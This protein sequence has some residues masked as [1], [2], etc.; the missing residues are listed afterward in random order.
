MFNLFFFF[1]LTLP[2]PIPEF[3]FF[4]VE[5]G[6]LLFVIAEF[7]VGAAALYIAILAYQHS[8]RKRGRPKKTKAEKLMVRLSKQLK[9]SIAL[10]KEDD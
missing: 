2:H 6:I 7:F 8:T 4:W 5:V 10:Q 9:E 1:F 3:W